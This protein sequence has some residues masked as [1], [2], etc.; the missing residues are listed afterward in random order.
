MHSNPI[1]PR[2]LRYQR[3]LHGLRIAGATGLAQGGD[4]IDVNAEQY[5]GHNT[6][7]KTDSLRRGQFD[8]LASSF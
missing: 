5:S 2:L 4:V 1:R 8:V 7:L 6:H 3:R